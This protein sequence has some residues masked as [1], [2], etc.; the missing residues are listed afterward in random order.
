[1]LLNFWFAAV[2]V[3]CRYA[4]RVRLVAMLCRFAFAGLFVAMLNGSAL[5]RLAI[6]GIPSLSSG[7]MVI[8]CTARFYGHSP[9]LRISRARVTARLSTAWYSKMSA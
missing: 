1:M 7:G 6:A 2:A 9:R 8:D 5:R 3:H 4:F